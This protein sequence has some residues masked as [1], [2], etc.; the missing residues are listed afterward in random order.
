MVESFNYRSKQAQVEKD[1]SSRIVLDCAR[2]VN[3][4]T[5]KALILRKLVL[6]I[7]MYLNT[8]R[9]NLISN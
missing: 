2:I 5:L 6:I 1:F 9:L 3:H 4:K 8:N 7:M